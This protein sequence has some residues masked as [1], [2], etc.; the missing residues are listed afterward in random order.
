MK[1]WLPP[2]PAKKDDTSEK[3]TPLRIVSRGMCCAVGHTAP[4]ATAAINARLNHFRE[5]EFVSQG[6]APIV[7]GALFD[8]AVWGAERLKYM[9]YSVIDEALAGLDLDTNQIAI[10]VIG[11]ET[12]RP[13]CPSHC[14]ADALTELLEAQHALGKP[15]HAASRFC[16][17]GKGGV[18]QAITAAATILCGKNG[19]EY[20]LLASADCL[21]DAGAIEHFLSKERVAS[22]DNT[23]GFIPAEGAAAL[24]LSRKGATSSAMWI[25]AAAA[26]Q[27]EWCIDSDLP[28][29][30]KGLTE[31]MR[32]A[33]S[34]SGS[35]IAAMDFHASG[36]TGE[37][38]YAKEVNLALSRCME[39]KKPAFPHLIVTRSTGE[40]GS[41]APLLTLAWLAGIMGHAYR[42][43][44]K[45]GLLHFAGDDG[46]RSALVVRFRPSLGS[47]G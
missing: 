37:G 29:R 42:S 20:V 8:V 32:S 39:R 7:G 15:F 18:A 10:V 2:F 38:W 5:T 21:L 14:L 40:T 46:Q 25:E 11:A 44:G 41:A 12:S 23:D 31:A 16:S 19:A 1:R 45:T 27:E 6:A 3:W 13:G 30:A 36:M 33:A 35:D 26:A 9:L 17:Y 47:A 4:A 24:L 28:L 43:P 22:G 34:A